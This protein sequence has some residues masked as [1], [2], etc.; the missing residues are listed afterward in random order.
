MK[1]KN[2]GHEF[3]AQYE[4]IKRI[5]KVYLFGAGHDGKMVLDVLSNRYKGIE[6]KGFIDNEKSLWGKKINGVKVFSPNEIEFKNDTGIIISFASEFIDSIDKQV[7]NMGFEIGKNAWHFE[8]FISIYA[9]YEHDE[10]FFSS[11][12]ILPTDACN[13]RC[14]ACLNFT[15]Y[16][17]NFTFRS[18]DKLKAEI[19]LYFKYIDYTGLFFI[20]GGEPFLYPDLPELISYINENYRG[21]MYEFGIVTNGTIKPSHALLDTLKNAKIRITFDDYRDSI[22][23]K[24]NNITSNLQILNELDKGED[25]I[26]R[27]YDEWISLFPHPV[28]CWDEDKL[29]ERYDKCHCPWQEYRDGGFYS[30]NYAAF[31]YNA[32]KG[33]PD[34]ENEFYSLKNYTPQ[35]KKELVEFRLGYTEKGYVEFCKKC[36]GY[37]EL[38]PYKVKAAEQ[39]NDER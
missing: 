37:M 16:I 21:K 4:N 28:G 20:S 1:W 23:D 18:I 14:K 26:V 9:A 19:D 8:Q 24:E 7:S 5:Q 36:A 34:M 12:C 27:K 3:D 13:L 15:N 33:V 2:K 29:I 25:L 31:A 22:P 6:I 39:E 38:N 11:I 30:C 35:K 10:V 17:K 32:E